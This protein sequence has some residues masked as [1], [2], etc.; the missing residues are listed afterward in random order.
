MAVR[1]RLGMASVATIA[2]V[3]G[4][5]LALAVSAPAMAAGEQLVTARL[6]SET[7]AL[8]PGGTAWLAVVCRGLGSARKA[9]DDPPTALG[10]H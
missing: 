9:R 10:S 4:A 8:K 6:L 5:A 2:P 3:L 1:P 7:S